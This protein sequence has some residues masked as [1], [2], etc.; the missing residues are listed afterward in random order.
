MTTYR[1]LSEVAGLFIKLDPDDTLQIDNIVTDSGTLN[2]GSDSLTT[3]GDFS[4]NSISADTGNLTITSPLSIG[5]NH[6]NAADVYFDISTFDSFVVNTGNNSVVT[7]GQS[8]A[9]ISGKDNTM[10]GVSC[11]IV[12][13]Q[14]NNITGNTLESAIVGGNDNVI[15]NDKTFHG[16][17]LNI[18]SDGYC[19]YN[20]GGRAITITGSYAGNIGGKDN[21]VNATRAVTIGGGSQTCNGYSSGSISGWFSNVQ[22][23]YAVILGGRSQEIAASTNN[24]AVLGGYNSTVNGDDSAAISGNTNNIQADQAVICGGEQHQILTACYAGFIGGGRNNTINNPK[25][26]IIGGRYNETQNFYTA[27]LGGQ[28]NT[29]SGKYAIAHGFYVDNPHWAS[30]GFAGGRQNS[31]GDTQVFLAHVSGTCNNNTVNLTLDGVNGGES[32]VQPFSTCWY[33]TA[34][35]VGYATGSI[36]GCG[37]RV[38]AAT[39]RGSGGGSV[40][41]PGPGPANPNIQI[42]YESDSNFNMALSIPSGGIISIDGIFNAE[43]RWSASVLI[44]QVGVF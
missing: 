6:I 42:D 31:T 35:V 38:T 14:S 28:N 11:A 17:G 39:I 18:T 5:G 37:Y 21:T 8:S 16:G 12:A 4:C 41:L 30:H 32:L 29:V 40:F 27:I 43:A 13:G 44:T 7:S 26:A 23:D 2:L 22:G 34:Y 33:I 1:A 3:N 19:A 36:V 24:S 9:I 15:Q 10:N 25:S 20:L